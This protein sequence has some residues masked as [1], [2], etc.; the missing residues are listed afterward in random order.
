M[1]KIVIAIAII[2]ALVAGVLFFKQQNGSG[3]ESFISSI[4]K[5]SS[6]DSGNFEALLNYVPNDT[7]YLFGNRDAVPEEYMNRQIERIETIVKSFTEIL[8]EENKDNN[9]T[10]IKFVS[11]YYESF[12]TAYKSN[13]LESMGYA[14]GQ[15]FVLY[16]Y[17]S[18]PV[19]RAEIVDNK[20][21][22]NSINTIAKKS[23]LPVKWEKCGAYECLQSED[24]SDLS[25]SF[26]VKEKSIVLSLYSKIDKETV[27]AHLMQAG[28]T[29]NHYSMKDFNSFLEQNNFQ[30][31]GDGFINIEK[32]TSLLLA[33]TSSNLSGNEK[34][35]FEKCAPIANDI[36]KKIPNITIGS[37]ELSAKQM[38]MLMI[39]NMDGNLTHSL[40]DLTNKNLFTERVANPLFDLGIN[41]NA[42]GL[43]RGIMDFANYMG[44]EAEKYGCSE[45]DAQGLRQG[46]AM[47][48][49]SIGMSIGQVSELYLAINEL[50]MDTKG[51]MPSKVSANVQIGAENPASLLQMLK[52][53][54]PPLAQLNIPN[55][56][57]EVDLLKVLPQPAPPFIKEFTA[58]M[59][60]KNINL[61][62]GEKVKME[63]FNPKEHTLL[64]LKVDNQKYYKM[65]SMVMET[66][67]KMQQSSLQQM[68]QE[69]AK[70]YK[71][72]LDDMQK[73][74]DKA[75]KL[76]KALY[77]IDVISSQSIYVDDRGLVMEVSQQEK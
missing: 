17:N 61:R 47:A 40:K 8:A 41:L 29:P 55:T 43:S 42:N 62:V 26:I 31:F 52:M 33:E 53:F 76:M 58:S 5:K 72:M 6:G 14:K 66:S 23:N 10:S 44:A 74:N 68:P 16:G 24:T 9:S 70:E 65:L 30:G 20:A 75:Q 38:R 25:L 22:I 64:W 57:E 2:V 48:S 69:E 34:A 37:T 45:I 28:T 35:S 18:Y 19:L 73:Q 39:F 12:L 27:T 71:K 46:A 56:G 60:G 32:L 13:N 67:Q 59:K 63:P 1:K 36:A 11:N 3:G 7:A 4:K 51:E 77:E 50:E 49:M 21:F 54:V 15:R